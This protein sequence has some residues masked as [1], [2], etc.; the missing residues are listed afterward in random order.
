[1]FQF[2]DDFDLLLAYVVVEN[3]WLNLTFLFCYV[4]CQ[5]IVH[6]ALLERIF[7]FHWYLHLLQA[8]FTLIVWFIIIIIENN[9]AGPTLNVSLIFKP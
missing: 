5:H 3:V 4:Y 9:Y 1:M 8:D 6:S 2:S 7:E